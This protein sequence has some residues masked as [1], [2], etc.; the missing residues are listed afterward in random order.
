MACIDYDLMSMYDYHQTT[1]HNQDTTFPDIPPT[2]D[3]QRP[4]QLNV[5]N[6]SCHTARC[7]VCGAD[8]DAADAAIDSGGGGATDYSDPD[9]YDSDDRSDRGEAAVDGDE[10]AEGHLI[11]VGDFGLIPLGLIHA[12]L[13]RHSRC[14][15]HHGILPSKIPSP[16]PLRLRTY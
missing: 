10:G 8:D 9:G 3:P 16:S 13:A 15:C 5:N 7:C 4:P 14:T 12:T 6:V 2:L 11:E 1:W